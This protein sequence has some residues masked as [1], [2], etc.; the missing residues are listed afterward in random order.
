MSF[1]ELGRYYLTCKG[2]KSGNYDVIIPKFASG[3]RGESADHRTR[4]CQICPHF[5]EFCLF[6]IGPFLGLF[7]MFFT[8]THD[9]SPPIRSR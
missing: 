1:R 2:S 5:H 7:C 8:Y 4:Y 6:N 3:S 9:L